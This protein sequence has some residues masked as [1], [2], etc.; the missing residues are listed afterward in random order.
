MATEKL[1]EYI[2]NTPYES[3]PEQARLSARRAILD[4]L[5]VTLAGFDDEGSKL[6][7]EFVKEQ[8]GK[9][10]AGVIGQG[11]RTTAA[12]AALANGTMAHVLDYD[13]Y[14]TTFLGHPSVAILPAVLA[15]AEKEHLSGKEALAAYILGTPSGQLT[16][17]LEADQAP[18]DIPVQ[19]WQALR[20]RFQEHVQ[21]FGHIFY[22][23]D[24][25]NLLPLD[26]PAPMLVRLGHKS[27]GLPVSRVIAALS[28]K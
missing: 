25:A 7:T 28:V 19:D 6:I 21:R 18:V 8:E 1:A 22:T 3:I 24:F 13:D 10:E 14:S 2:V 20:Q 15:V 11:F 27:T 12:Y 17:Q 16:A 5:G 26:N 9:T 23:M 4:C